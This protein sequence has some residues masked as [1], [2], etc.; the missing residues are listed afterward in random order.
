MILQTKKKFINDLSKK[1]IF[2]RM[3]THQTTQ[4]IDFPNQNF[5]FK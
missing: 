5:I 4:L 1:Y 3:P 2:F